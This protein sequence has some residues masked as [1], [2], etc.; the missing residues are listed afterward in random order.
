MVRLGRSDRH[1]RPRKALAGVE[2]ARRLPGGTSERSSQLAYALVMRIFDLVVRTDTGYCPRMG[3]F[4]PGWVERGRIDAE[5]S[6]LVVAR[7]LTGKQESGSEAKN[8]GG[9]E[10]ANGGPR[11]HGT[12]AGSSPR[13]RGGR[14]GHP[15]LA[16][17]SPV[18]SSRLA[19]EVLDVRRP[20]TVCSCSAS[21][22]STWEKS[23]SELEHRT[24]R[25]S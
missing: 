11:S 4:S 14:P 22:E 5:N 16:E 13:V 2:P 20:Y 19:A 8:T 18:S 23:F 6:R 12:I 21:K 15:E 25:S 17:P 9:D 7:P 24:R 3:K 1:V 10:S